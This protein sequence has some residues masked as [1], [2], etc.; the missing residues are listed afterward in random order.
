[1][2]EEGRPVPALPLDEFVLFDNGVRQDLAL[3]SVGALPIDVTLVLDASASV[4]GNAIRYLGRDVDAI[5]TELEPED[6]VRLL[7]FSQVVREMA[8]MRPADDRVDLRLVAPGGATAFY[9]AIAAALLPRAEPG[10]PHLVVALGDGGDNASW[11]DAADLDAIARRADVVLHVVVRDPWANRPRT[12]PGSGAYGWLPFS[13]PSGSD[14]LEDVAETTG[15]TYHRVAGDEPLGSLFTRIVRDFKAG[16]L[17]WFEPKGV[18]IPG[19]HDLTVQL[20][21]GGYEV[22]ARR[23]YFGG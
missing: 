1:V 15:G 6:R 9:N 10:R 14:G 17:L 11:L 19:W 13:A 21:S 23:G 16:Y 2:L 5:V 12:T 18:A 4:S 20:R 22:R 7:T 3:M 8:P